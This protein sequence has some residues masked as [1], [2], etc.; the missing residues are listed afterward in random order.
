MNTLVFPLMAERSDNMSGFGIPISAF[1][2]I[3]ADSSI[4]PPPKYGYRFA[5]LTD[6]S[7]TLIITVFLPI[8]V[9]SGTVI[10][11]R[12]EMINGKNSKLG[13]DKGSC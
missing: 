1:T 10:I 11:Q 6:K 5:G 3:R 8:R 12:F 2:G 13:Q 9:T 7:D 4:H